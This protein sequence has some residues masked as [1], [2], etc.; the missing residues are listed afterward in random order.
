MYTSSDF[1]TDYEGELIDLGDEDEDED[2]T[3]ETNDPQKFTKMK[4]LESWFYQIIIFKEL[5]ILSNY[6]CPEP[7]F[8]N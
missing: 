3:P 1:E 4:I 6:N 8:G 7:F 2:K 5:M